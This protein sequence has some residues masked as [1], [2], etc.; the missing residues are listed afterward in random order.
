MTDH[1]DQHKDCCHRV[2]TNK[3][4]PRC[5]V[6]L[7]AIHHRMKTSTGKPRGI[8]VEV[9]CSDTEKCGVHPK[10]Y[11]SYGFDVCW[12]IRCQA[13]T[14]KKGTRCTRWFTTNDREL[15][16]CAQHGG[17]TPGSVAAAIQRA[18]DQAVKTLN[19]RHPDRVF[20]E[21]ELDEE[22]RRI[23]PDAFEAAKR[24]G[25]DGPD[26]DYE[27]EPYEPDEQEE[28]DGPYEPDEPDIQHD[29]SVDPGETEERSP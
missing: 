15:V 14:K 13:T 7:D 3:A 6:R 4:C 2:A 18:A 5:G 28:A 25:L 11:S 12:E 26:E 9:V 1:S 16:H 19:A 10:P 22:M 20:T 24:L 29:E 23:A 21:K 27:S 17:E 8:R